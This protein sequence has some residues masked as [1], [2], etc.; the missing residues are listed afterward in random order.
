[1]Q[2]KQS[3]QF[4]QSPQKDEEGKGKDGQKK[5]RSKKGKTEFS[6]LVSGKLDVESTLSRSDQID[7]LTKTYPP[8]TEVVVEETSFFLLTYKSF[9]SAKKVETGKN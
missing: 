2:F 6:R 3:Q 7:E 5:T 1:M 8:E 9:K 4:K